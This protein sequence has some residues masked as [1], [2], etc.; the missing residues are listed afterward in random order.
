MTR[1]VTAAQMHDI[2]A[3]AF[4]TDF[5]T[6]AQMLMGLAGQALARAVREQF[7]STCRVAV[8]CGKGNNGGDGFSAASF[9]DAAGYRCSVW[10]LGG[11]A[12]GLSEASAFFHRICINRGIIVEGF[13]AIDEVDCI[14]DC[15][16]GT[17]FKGRPR[18][19]LAHIIRMINHAPAFVVSA[20]MPSA[21]SSDGA[22]AAADEIVHAAVT[23]TMG[24]PKINLVQYPGRNYAGKL[25][26]ADIGFPSDIVDRVCG[27]GTFLVNDATV[28]ALAIDR[29]DVDGNKYTNGHCAIIGGFPGMEG[30]ALLAAEAA[31]TAGV[32]LCTVFTSDESRPVIA[33]K[34]PE[35]MTVSI[36]GALSDDELRGFFAAEISRKKIRTLLIGPGLGRGDQQSRIFHAA[37][38]AACD[39]LDSIVL[40]GDAL[41]FLSR[42]GFTLKPGKTELV[43][44]PHAGEGA[45]L[46]DTDAAAIN[47]DPLSAAAALSARFNCTALLKGPTSVS[48]G[49]DRR[50]INMSGNQSLGTGGSGDVLAGICSAFLSRG[51]VPDQAAAAGAYV[52]GRAADLVVE[53]T[54]AQIIRAR[55]IIL[56][57]REAMIPIFGN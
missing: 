40:D 45:R 54:Q 32:G 50:F 19:D 42:D 34:V 13:P 43:L 24:L 15:L 28:S 6:S 36:P 18:E 4:G 11:S 9:L 41:W 56:S 52:H 49:K 53:R 26:V 31:L 46:L 39:Q 29:P 20:D 48:A 3:S 21:L 47:G 57:L 55:D 38:S 22:V 51:I 37:V 8:I 16:T 35:I 25:V 17:G 1:C 44:T 7:P 27:A 2:E 30:A 14:L 10:I 33:G 5:G 23:V 12:S